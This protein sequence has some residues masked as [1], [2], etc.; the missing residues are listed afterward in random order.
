MNQENIKGVQKLVNAG[1]SENSE[2][3][4]IDDTVSLVDDKNDV[5]PTLFEKNDQN[6]L[7]VTRCL[8]QEI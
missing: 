8:E 4:L 7:V 1:N 6:K 3:K 2:D 5:P